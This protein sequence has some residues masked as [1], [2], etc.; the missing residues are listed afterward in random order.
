M[1]LILLGY[2]GSGKSAVGKKLAETLQFDFLDLDSEIEKAEDNS[3]SEIFET[4]G[5]IYFRKR[6]AEILN[7]ITSEEKSLVLA[8]GG[9]TPCYG[10]T[11]ENLLAKNNLITIYL[12]VPLDVLTERLSKEAKQ[13][14]LIAH[15]EKKEDLNDFIR[16]HLFE[17]AYF[18]NRAELTI[19][20]EDKSVEQLVR[21]IV[22]A[23]F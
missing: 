6:E 17:R 12:N 19:D 4:R 15:L 23:L 18:Y 21:M 13:R 20:A 16:K 5:E 7:R 2:M 14:P 10:N 1:K 9:G 22:A 3:I 11:M 8:T